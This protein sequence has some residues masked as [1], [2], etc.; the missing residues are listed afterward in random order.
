MDFLPSL[1]IATVCELGRRGG[2]YASEG[3]GGDESNEKQ[4]GAAVRTQ[5][6]MMIRIMII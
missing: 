4:M 1:A 6:I 3:G 5:G 2:S